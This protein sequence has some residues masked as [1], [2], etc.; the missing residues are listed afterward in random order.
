MID[1]K[2][3]LYYLQSQYED[4][5]L[6]KQIDEMIEE[7]IK[8]ADFKVSYQ[9]Y[10]KEQLIKER[11][12]EGTDVDQFLISCN[13]CLIMVATLGMSVDRKI[14]QYQVLDI[15][16]AYVL[17][18]VANVYLEQQCDK[19]Y[20]ELKL[21]YQKH[22]L[23]LSDRFS[24]GYG[25]YPLTCQKEYIRLLQTNK[26]IGVYC[27][28]NSLLVP[29]KSMSGIIGISKQVQPMKIRGCNYCMMKDTCNL[30]KVGKKCG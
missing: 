18:A 13:E 21:Y 26:K 12:I 30:R 11:L 25:N 14:K 16:K 6:K 8:I 17:N 3:V 4:E 2:Q 15:G 23:Y 7:L 22:N 9:V 1:R 5:T 29:S 10:N 24:C 20:D 19:L 28:E 27:N